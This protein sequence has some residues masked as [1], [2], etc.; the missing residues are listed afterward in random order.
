M[1]WAVYR[2]QNML[3]QRRLEYGLAMISLLIARTMG[4]SKDAGLDDFLFDAGR[5]KK[6]QTAEDAAM[7]IG[8]GRVH[9]LGQK[10]KR[11]R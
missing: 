9:H 10:R 7:F 3:P 5:K 4:G 11:G 1:R 2:S 8:G 6:T